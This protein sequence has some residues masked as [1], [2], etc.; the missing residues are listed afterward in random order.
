MSDADRR[1]QVVPISDSVREFF[2]ALPDED[3]IR[4][5]QWTDEE[6]AEHDAKVKAGRERSDREATEKQMR[7]RLARFAESGFPERAIEAAGKADESAALIRRVASWKLGEQCVLVLSGSRG[8]GKTVAA[9]WWAMS[10]APSDAMF[11]RAATLARSS[12]YDRDDRDALL[13]ASALVLDDL[14]EEFMDAKGSFLVD[15]D[16]LIDVFYG[17]KRP[18]LI[19]TNCTKDV[20]VKRYGARIEDRLRECGSWFSVG[21][22]SQRRKP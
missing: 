14:G 8:C 19:T 6:W 1:G 16:E 7:S 5:P 2:A 11:V 15:L 17:R 20:F 9:T 12:R 10:H 13:R 4:P 21:E 3:D 18:L 22:V